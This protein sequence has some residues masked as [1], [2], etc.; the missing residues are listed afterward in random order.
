MSAAINLASYLRPYVDDKEAVTVDGS[1]V[2]ECLN[3]LIKQYPGMKKML[4]DKS[5]K[6][7]DYVSVFVGGAIAYAD[8]LDKPVKDGDTLHILYIIG[9]G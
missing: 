2:R 6:L 4:F 9:G 3:A 8:E 1:T 5:G 7:H